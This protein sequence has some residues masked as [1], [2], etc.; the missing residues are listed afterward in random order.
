[1]WDRIASL[2]DRQLALERPAL[3]AAL[4]LAA[5]QPGEELLDVGTGTGAMLRELAR[6]G[7]RPRRVVGVDSSPAMLAAA[8]D[9]A[10]GSKLV[11]ADAR[12][13]PFDAESYDLVTMAYVLHVLDRGDRARVL[14]EIARVLRPGGRLVTVTPGSPGALPGRLLLAP[15]A[16]VARRSSGPAAGLRTL[17][18]RPELTGP[19]V[20]RR[21]R[22][23]NRGYPSTCVLAHRRA[24]APGA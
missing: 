3:R 19:F 10:P 9:R 14:E 15:V 8:R 16:A 4:D 13:L 23:V 22:W 12:E 24:G 18:P 21:A 17:D 20:V 5:P 6:R 2:Y 7:D 1:M 11:A